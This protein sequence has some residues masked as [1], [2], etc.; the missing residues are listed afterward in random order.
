MKNL[1]LYVIVFISGAA[2]L[3]MEIL[4]TRILGPFYGVSLF[5][6]SALIT[7]TLA[8]LSAGYA[9]GGRWADKGATRFRLCTLIAGAGIWLLLIPW[10]KRPVLALTEPLGLRF[11]VLVAA[12]VLFAPPLTLLG[13][14][15]PYAIKLKTVRLEEVGR[16]AGN[17]YAISTVASVISALLTG[18]FLI[19]NFGV[20]RLTLTIGVILLMTASIGLLDK[21]KPHVMVSIVAVALV[22]G[23]IV[24]WRMPTNDTD[25]KGRLLAV[26]QSAYAEIRV[27]DMHS[28]RHLLIDGGIHTI[29]DPL[30]WKSHYPYVA[31]VDLTKYFFEKPGQLLLIGLGGGSVVKNFA[32]EGWTVEAVEIDPVVTEVAYK[33]FGLDSSEAKIFHLDGRQFLLTHEETYDIIM[34]DAFGSSSIPFHLVTVE[35]F[36]LIASHLNPG[37]ALAINIEANGWHDLMV[38]SLAAT[39]KQHFP[40]VQ[41]LP[42]SESSESLGNVIILAS[43]AKLELRKEL[44]RNYTDL[45]KRFSANYQQNHA[46]DN[47]FVPDTRNA[48]V[49]TDDLNP[50]DLWAEAI[51]LAARKD[52]HRY[53]EQSGLSW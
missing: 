20:S 10:I 45:D 48:P 16:S 44:E 47:R 11:A 5:L 33:H 37:G 34:M 41:V 40:E 19:P 12:F 42:A 29:V 17:L 27:L 23:A 21:Q 49:L 38:R 53:F 2:V 9:V 1:D 51:N 43:H 24:I 13:M 3:A 7:V 35:A 22:I 26:E 15:S 30:T 4:G 28:R 6:W 18:F 31:V 39:L 32:C 52:L 36:G 46:W 50:V 25:P 8:A 14:V